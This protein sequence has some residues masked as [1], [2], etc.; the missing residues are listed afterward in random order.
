VVER[1]VL[2]RGDLVRTSS[3]KSA[4]PR[5]PGSAPEGTAVQLGRYVY[6]SQ[7][8]TLHPPSRIHSIKDKTG[9]DVQTM[10]Y[11]PLRISDYVFV[12]ANTH[13]RAA[14]IRSNVQI[15]AN[16]TIGNM[17]TIKDNVKILDGTVLPDYSNWASGTIVA[18]RPAR[19]VG[20][21]GPG[22]GSGGAGGGTSVDE[23]IGVRS[24]ERYAAVNTKK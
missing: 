4:Q 7:G 14:E 6:I 11:Y 21:L 12:G 2:I 10:L 16:C 8:C 17:C 18:G 5:E 19:I 15:G 1:D 13:I 3:S 24:R 20:E 9:Q 23:G 22:W